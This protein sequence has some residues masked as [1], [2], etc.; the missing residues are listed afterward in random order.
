MERAETIIRV[1]NALDSG[2]MK[3]ARSIARAEWPFEPVI[4]KPRKMSGRQ[5]MAIWQ[6]DGFVDRYFGT[7]LIYPGALR[8]LARLMPE[9]FPYHRN[10]RADCCHFV[11]WELY[12]SHDHVVPLARGGVDGP[13]NVVTTSMLRNQ[14]KANWLLDEIGWSLQPPGNIREWDGL[15][16]WFLGAV[17]R[18][19]DVLAQDS[20]LKK[21]VLLARTAAGR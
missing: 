12:P 2:D 19:A 3:A 7:R 21:W 5:L 13:D 15:T 18:Y 10:G 1:C 17:E 20:G 11:H 6:R 14:V 8:L 16:R 9:E 4:A